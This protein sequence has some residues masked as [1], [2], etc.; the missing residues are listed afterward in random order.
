MKEGQVQIQ[1][2]SGHGNDHWKGYSTQ[3]R[4]GPIREKSY[5]TPTSFSLRLRSSSSAAALAAASAASF[6]GST[7]ACQRL[8]LTC[9]TVFQHLEP[10]AGPPGGISQDTQ[11]AL[12][13]SLS[14]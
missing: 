13:R 11:L 2:W 3:N 8:T 10:E 12:R 7:A 6:S 5:A 1:P 9:I 4:P 14:E